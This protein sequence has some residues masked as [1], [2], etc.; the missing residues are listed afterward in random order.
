[1]LEA[2]RG[3]RTWPFDQPNVAVRSTQRRLGA[4]PS[5]RRRLASVRCQ[6]VE[7]RST[8][9]VGDRVL[10]SGGYDL[11]PVWLA[12]GPGYRGCIQEIRGGVGLPVVTEQKRTL[13][14][15]HRIRVAAGV[16][17]KLVG[18]VK[19]RCRA[20]FRQRRGS[21]QDGSPPSGLWRIRGLLDRAPRALPPCWRRHLTSRVRVAPY[22][23]FRRHRQPVGGAR[24][25]GAVK[26]S[27]RG[28]ASPPAADE[29]E[30]RS[31]I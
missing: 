7:A 25:W 10:V 19:G 27:W 12:G 2:R 23:R 6:P 28:F 20:R 17:R 1:V 29:I 30:R 21:L 14:A 31:R 5:W 24:S 18:S 13:S 9:N 4:R 3:I 8:F 22:V 16:V 15:G 26:S 11:N